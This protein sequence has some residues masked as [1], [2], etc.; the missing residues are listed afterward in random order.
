MTPCTSASPPRRGRWVRSASS[1]FIWRWASRCRTTTFAWWWHTCRRQQGKRGGEMPAS[2]R[3]EPRASARP[4]L[5]PPARGMRIIPVLDVM[6]GVVVRGV[7]GRRSEYRPLVSRLT[8]SCRPEDVAAAL[9][10]HFGFTEF[11]VAD[12][13]A[14]AGHDFTCPFLTALHDRG[15][16]VWLDAGVV[17]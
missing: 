11:Y 13:D 9:H 15:F 14:I 2:P 3:R 12:L 10:S 8:P 16:R 7:A 1:R 5:A 17:D 4:W 6:N